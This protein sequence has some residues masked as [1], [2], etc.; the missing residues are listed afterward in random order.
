MSA[1]ELAAC[2]L[3]QF[4]FEPAMGLWT[5]NAITLKNCPK[6]FIDHPEAFERFKL[7]ADIAMGETPKIQPGD[8]V[9]GAFIEP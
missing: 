3:K 5:H 2:L 1:V 9:P 7:D 6:Y 8:L 4:G